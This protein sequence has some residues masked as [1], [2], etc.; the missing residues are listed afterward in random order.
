MFDFYIK[1]VNE[2]G[3]ADHIGYT[4]LLPLNL[5]EDN[6][7]INSVITGNNHKPIGQF[8]TEY[9]IVKPLKGYATTLVGLNSW[10]V[11]TQSLVSWLEIYLKLLTKLT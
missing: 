8:I 11:I 6:G 9:L 3:M 7:T 1:D 2:T 10:Q 4:Y 5:Q